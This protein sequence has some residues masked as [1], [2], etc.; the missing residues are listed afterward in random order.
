MFLSFS[1]TDVATD[2]PEKTT[3]QGQRIAAVNCRMA[4][5]LDVPGGC[6]EAGFHGSLAWKSWKW[7]WKWWP[8]HPPKLKLQPEREW[9]DIEG[10]RFWTRTGILE[11]NCGQSL[12][13]HEQTQAI[14]ALSLTSKKNREY[15]AIDQTWGMR[16]S[17]SKT[18]VAGC[19][20]RISYRCCPRGCRR[21]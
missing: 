8:G 17:G 18:L 1:V 15:M 14:S 20:S 11:S 16:A 2:S 5:F 10:T 21:C 12:F 4:E 7:W 6:R 3:S 9:I 13:L 19:L